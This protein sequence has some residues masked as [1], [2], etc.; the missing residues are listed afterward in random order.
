MFVLTPMLPGLN[1][2]V[3]K[4]AVHDGNSTATSTMSWEE[5]SAKVSCSSNGFGRKDLLDVMLT[6]GWSETCQAPSPAY[7]PASSAVSAFAAGENMVGHMTRMHAVMN[8]V[9]AQERA[10]H[11]SEISL[12]L[13]RI[14]KDLK[15]T[16]QKVEGTFRA[17]SEQLRAALQA[18][19]KAAFGEDVTA[20]TSFQNEGVANLGMINADWV[21][22]RERA[23]Q[24]EILQLRSRLSSYESA[25]EHAAGL[26][27]R[28]EQMAATWT[29]RTR[30]AGGTHRPR[31]LVT[32]PLGPHDLRGQDSPH[33]KIKEPW[34]ARSSLTRRKVSTPRRACQQDRLL[35][36]L[37]KAMPPLC[38]LSDVFAHLRA[39]GCLSA[40]L[41]EGTF[42]DIDAQKTLGTIVNAFHAAAPNL[43]GLSTLLLSLHEELSRQSTGLDGS[44]SPGASGLASMGSEISMEES[45]ADPM[46]PRA[47]RAY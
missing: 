22:D 29:K 6:R 18:Q 24:D 43:Q 3:K 41:T 30:C 26:L 19:A 2:K 13:R 40:V 42:H 36:H 23:L 33:C 31:N 14:E 7:H 17:L 27:P 11:S 46:S 39:S 20:D 15:E 32:E 10:R 38:L 28:M 12:L 16:F 8:Q 45:I 37:K 25:R 1:S 34:P 47:C 9:L 5:R 4:G 35:Q 21:Q 44:I